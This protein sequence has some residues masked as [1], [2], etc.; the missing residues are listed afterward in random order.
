M[1][2]FGELLTEFM[3]RT[4]TSDSELARTLGVRRQTIFRWKEGL[5]ERPRHRD[6]ILLIAKK[7][8]LTPE[9]RKIMEKHAMVGADCLAAIQARLGDNDFLGMASEIAAAHHEWWDGRGYPLRLKGEEI[10]L[11]ARI[12][13]VADVYDALTTDRVY[14]DAIPHLEA[15]RM[16]VEGAG[17]QFDPDL[18]E[19]FVDCEDQIRAVAEQLSADAANALER[20][21]EPEAL[22]AV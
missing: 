21:R 13:A 6:D 8:R 1:R 3:H 17:T 7:L 12:V 16:I 5:V 2:T 14:K 11:S 19:A 10:P 20:S 4:G 18:I 9:E 22:A 15:C